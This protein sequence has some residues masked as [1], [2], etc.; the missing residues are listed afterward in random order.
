MRPVATIDLAAIQSN[1]ALAARQTPG[2]EP[3]AV[4]KADAYGHGATPVAESLLAGGCR[5]FAVATVGEAV[6]LRDAGIAAPILV[7]GGAGEAAE[8]EACASHALV[9]VIHHRAQLE[10]LK[11]TAPPRPIDVHV[12][13]DTGMR[14]MGVGADHAVAL[15]EAAD[16]EP[17]VALQG[18]YT[19]FARADEADL[20]PTQEQLARFGQVLEAAQARG[21]APPEVHAANSA[22]ILSWEVLRAASAGQ[23]ATRPGLMLYGVPPAPHFEAALQPAMTLVAHIVA[24]RPVRRG[25]AVGY[26]A[27]F[28]AERDTRIATLAIGY[29]DGVPISAAR[30]RSVW[31]G[32]R[33]LPIAGRVSMDFIGVDVGDAPVALGDPALLF[34]ALGEAVW[35]VERSASDAGTIAYELLVRVGQRVQR[36]YQGGPSMRDGA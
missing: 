1:Y 18:V 24:L 26:S 14:R 33:R 23:T 3:I 10:R 12:E 30:G 21:V 36:R 2:L 22:G 19:H 11:E 28:R 4:I 35:P 32:G 20:A 25:E 15:L 13:V 9:P 17:A 5:R 16:S 29:A 31:I 34:G 8:A 27:E 7:L 6:S